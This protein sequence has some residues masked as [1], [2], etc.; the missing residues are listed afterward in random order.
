MGL[1]TGRDVLERV[2]DRG[3]RDPMLSGDDGGSCGHRG[4]RGHRGGNGSTDG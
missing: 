3:R 4:T 2:L 1:L